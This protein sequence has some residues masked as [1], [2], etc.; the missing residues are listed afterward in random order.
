MPIAFAN[1]QGEGN[2]DLAELIVNR[3]AKIVNE[4]FET[5]WEME[6]ENVK[7]ECKLKSR[8]E[9]LR[10]T[11]QGERTCKAKSEWH[12]CASQLLTNNSISCDTFANSAKELLEKVRGKFRNIMLTSVANCEKNVLVESA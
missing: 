12:A 5:A 8:M 9:L 1:L 6:T 10:E 4:V 11:R 7:Q 2:I 3:G